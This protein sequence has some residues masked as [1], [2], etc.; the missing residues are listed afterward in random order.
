VLYF[1]LYKEGDGFS[2]SKFALF[3]W[4][5]V[6]FIF[7]FIIAFSMS[8]GPVFWVYISE[9]LPPMGIGLVVLQNWLLL[10]LLYRFIHSQ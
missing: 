8:L 3:Q 6:I 2:D 5:I 9:I 7:A 1:T 4:F 10:A